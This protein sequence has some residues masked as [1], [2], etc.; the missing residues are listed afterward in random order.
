MDS[1]RKSFKKYMSDII[2]EL[3]DPKPK[4][5]IDFAMDDSSRYIA[6]MVDLHDEMKGN[7]EADPNNHLLYNLD[8]LMALQTHYLGS[9]YSH[10][11]E[12]ARFGS[13]NEKKKSLEIIRNK[14]P[15]L[16]P[17]MLQMTS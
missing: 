9:K 2:L 12:F 7:Q 6:N 10:I 15:H 13:E 5:P 3:K 17:T 8:A 11:P 14:F 16:I 1:Y 4:T